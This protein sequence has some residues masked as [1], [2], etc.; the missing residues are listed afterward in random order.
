MIKMKN[1]LILLI[2]FFINSLIAE[3]KND[4]KHEERIL[5]VLQEYFENVDQK[6]ANGMLKHLTPDFVLHFDSNK[7]MN[8]KSESDFNILFNNWKKSKKSKFKTTK[9][10]SI[11]IQETHVIS[12]YAAVADV[13]FTRKDADGNNIRTERAL[14][15]LI[16]GKGYYGSPIKFIWGILTKWSRPW[17]IY[18]ISNIELER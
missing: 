10:E 5:N 16:R 15:H 17:K 11:D 7:I 13:V 12:N 18:M 6:N 1:I 3:S 8:I 14:Y 2:L 4:F 9:I